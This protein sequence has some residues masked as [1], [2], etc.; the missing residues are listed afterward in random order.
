MARW[1]GGSAGCVSRAY[2]F[3][4][5]S[6]TG[7]TNEER[8]VEYIHALGEDSGVEVLISGFF[9]MPEVEQRAFFVALDD[10]VIER[11][12]P[13][14]AQLVPPV[15]AVQQPPPPLMIPVEV[16]VRRGHRAKV[17]R[18]TV[19]SG[20]WRPKH[21]HKQLLGGSPL[22]SSWRLH[23]RMNDCALVTRPRKASHEMD[24]D[25]S[26]AVTLRNGDDDYGLLL[27]ELRSLLDVELA[28]GGLEVVAGAVAGFSEPGGARLHMSG[29]VLEGDLLMRVA[30]EDEV[31]AL[32]PNG[33]GGGVAPARPRK[34]QRSNSTGDVVDSTRVIVHSNVVSVNSVERTH[35]QALFASI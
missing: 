22:H 11:P 25:E 5:Q 8:V 29:N 28:C 3:L 21:H 31:V 23:I 24:F 1:E 15:P 34:L 18:V 9:E 2:R 4:P 27:V 12:P 6:V 14:P 35:S 20:L 13:P 16:P 17:L 26:F 10:P 30:V 33:N 7:A 19:L 32:L